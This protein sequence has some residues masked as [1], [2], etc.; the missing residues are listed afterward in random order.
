MFEKNIN[1]IDIQTVLVSLIVIFITFSRVIP[2]I[3]NFTPMIALAIFGSLHFKNRNLAYILPI[4]SLW[5]SDFILNNYFYNDSK[6]IIWFYE[7]YYW[8]YLSYVVIILLSSNFYN[9]IINFRNVLILGV[10]SSFI[11]FIITNFGFWLTSS[12][13]TNDLSGLINCYVLAIPFYKGTIMGTLFFTP[14][15]IVSYYLL[16]KKIY[17][18]KCE[19]LIYK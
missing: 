18:F 9:T 19:H 17:L 12:L 13:Y 4:L 11:F 10:S 8:Q 5:V 16:Q 14:L 3:Y 1:K 6:E 15:F 2:H 7:G